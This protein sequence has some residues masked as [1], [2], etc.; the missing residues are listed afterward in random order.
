MSG[1]TVDTLRAYFERNLQNQ[2][3][4]LQAA[5][6]AVKEATLKS[7]TLTDIRFANV[8][9]LR[10][11]LS[12]QAA[13][14]ITRAEAAAQFIAI[15]ARLTAIRNELGL[16]L[17]RE[18]YDTVLLDFQSWRSNV[19]VNATGFLTIDPWERYIQR[20]HDEVAFYLRQR[21][22]LLVAVFLSVAG[23]FLRL[24]K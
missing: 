14:N 15:D 21:T 9:E 16:L 11:A 7:E 18:V 10:G 23:T 4:A 19:D 8:N 17:P 5:L 12:D 22:G 13:T 6:E 20:Q 2:Q 3:V 24:L 1:W